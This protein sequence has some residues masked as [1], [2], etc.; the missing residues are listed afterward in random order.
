MPGTG[1]VGKSTPATQA[2]DKP[3]QLEFQQRPAP[4]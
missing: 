2:S 1:E 3:V 4:R